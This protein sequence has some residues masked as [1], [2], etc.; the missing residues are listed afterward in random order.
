MKKKKPKLA[1]FLMV[2]L[3]L[4]AFYYIYVEFGTTRVSAED[5]VNE[6]SNNKKLADEEYLNKEIELTGKVAAF[7]EFSGEENLLELESGN[8][9]T[10]LYCILSH[11]EDIEIAK[12]FTNGMNVKIIGTCIGIVSKKFPNSIYIKMKEFK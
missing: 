4:L 7:Y 10:G 5:L 6:Y 9:Q 11:N 3:L 2:V 1:N 8:D 12:S